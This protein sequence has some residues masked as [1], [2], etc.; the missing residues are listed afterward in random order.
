M[1]TSPRQRTGSAAGLISERDFQAGVIELARLCGWQVAHFHD[2]RRQVA[3]NKWVGDADAA[4]FP[5]LV[6]VRPPD[7]IF[8]ELKTDKGRMTDMQR[9]W[10]TNLEAVGD[11]RLWRPSDW[12][13]IK[14][15]L[16]GEK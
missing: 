8:A 14:K 16:I 5:D 15:T 13:E 4:G 6:L 2:S 12:P 7:L 10:Q 11:W 3:D 9:A 1:S